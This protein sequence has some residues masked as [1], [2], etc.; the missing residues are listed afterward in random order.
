MFPNLDGMIIL[1]KQIYEDMNALLMGWNR[2]TT[3][4]APTM[5]KYSKFM[6]VYSDFFKNYQNT[7]KKLKNLL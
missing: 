2:K 4:I 3:L 1:S 6:L 7:E 5:I